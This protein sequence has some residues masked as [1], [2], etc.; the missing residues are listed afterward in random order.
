MKD[1]FIRRKRVTLFTMTAR[2]RVIAYFEL[3]SIIS[4]LKPNLPE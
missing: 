4:S 2:P 3:V 1:L